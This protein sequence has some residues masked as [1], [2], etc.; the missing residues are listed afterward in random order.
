M[1]LVVATRNK[2]K[3][4]EIKT[5]LKGLPIKVISLNSFKDVPEV[6]E[7]GKTLEANARKKA[8]QVSRHLKKLAVADDSG[9]EVPVLGNRPGVYSARFSGNGA[10]YSSNN[11]KVL[12]LLKG[13]PISKRTACFRCVIAVADKGKVVGIAEGRCRGRIGFEPKGRAGF[14]YD[15]I[16][17]PNGHK[18]TFAE[19]GLKKK[20]RISHRGKAL[21]KAK[22]LI[23]DFLDDN[24]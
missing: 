9:L 7:D 13:T 22:K 11:K 6:I 5:L 4:K 21:V 10:T 12:R 2:D 16:F 24:C 23:I 18:K 14:G 1:K 3:L 8:I 20:N 15:P 19:M 17:V